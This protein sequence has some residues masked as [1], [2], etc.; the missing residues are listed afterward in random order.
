MSKI[1]DIIRKSWFFV[2]ILVILVI[3]VYERTFALLATLILIF[4][5]IISYIPS[6]SFKKR[7]IKSMNKYKKIEDFAISRNI[8]RPLPIV[9]NYMYKLSKHQKRRKWLIVYLNKR[10]IFYNKKTIQNFIKLYEYGFHEK[11][12]L[13]NLRSNTNLKTRAEIKAIRDTLTKHRRILEV[14]PQ[15]II[16][17]VKLNKSIRY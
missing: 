3:F 1:G 10:Y 11:E 17:E 9:Q 8:R 6:L 14:Q 13:E 7:L 2:L 15:E 4:G 5:F 16:E 12:I